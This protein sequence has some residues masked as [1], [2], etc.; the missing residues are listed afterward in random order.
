[1]APL[2]TIIADESTI[3]HYLPQ[4]DPMVM[5]GKLHATGDGVTTT[6]TIIHPENIFC[7]NGLFGEAGL[8]ENMAQTAAAG[9][10]YQSKLEQKEP[11]VGFIGGLKN[12]RIHALP[13]SGDE[14][15][16]EVRVEHQVFD[17]TL[18]TSSIY[19]NGTIIAECELKIF[20]IKS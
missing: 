17:A 6:S 9:I 16:T 15:V 3:D 18:A 7:E 12:L 4:K 19:L 14:I 5:I 10:G 2:E 11:P 8:I 13:H 20:I 1:M